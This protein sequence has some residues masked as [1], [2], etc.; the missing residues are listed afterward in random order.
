MAWTWQKWASINT[1]GVVSGNGE[2]WVSGWSRSGDETGGWG[3]KGQ[4]GSAG[5]TMTAQLVV[6]RRIQTE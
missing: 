5:S 4:E 2:Q 3:K 1:T 6:R